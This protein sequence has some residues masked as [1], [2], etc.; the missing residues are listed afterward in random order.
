MEGGNS[1][2]SMWFH[3]IPFTGKERDEETGYGYFGARYMD[4]E[5]M[6]MWL[7]VDRYADKYPFISPYAYCAWNSVKLVDP[8]GDTIINLYLQY[9]NS[10]GNKGDLY[11][12]TQQLIDDFQREHPEEFEFL[13]NLSFTDPFDENKKT[14][15][16]I[17]VGV[18]DKKGPVVNGRRPCAE[19]KY[20]FIAGVH[21][22]YDENGKRHEEI[23]PDGIFNNK[24]SITLYKHH[25][26]IGTLANEFGDAIF[27]VSRPKTVYAD[28][29]LNYN[30]RATTKFSFDYEDYIKGRTSIRPNPFDGETYK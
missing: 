21:V 23:F 27:A 29:N 11:A 6:T 3:P 4:H 16:N 25:H 15:V 28:Q 7:S 2:K 17:I 24:I 10:G 14:P 13:N 5:L 18:T 30:I 20:K 9:K 19:T 8:T 1:T 22:Y 12:R 26:D